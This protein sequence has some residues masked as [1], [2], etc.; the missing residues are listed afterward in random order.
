MC[1][2]GRRPLLLCSPFRQ[3]KFAV[4]EAGVAYKGYHAIKAAAFRTQAAQIIAAHHEHNGYANVSQLSIHS[5][6]RL[7]SGSL[8]QCQTCRP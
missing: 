4:G 1:G 7:F 8:D 3:I 2:L 6:D 5:I